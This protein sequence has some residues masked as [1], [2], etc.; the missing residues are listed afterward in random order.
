MIDALVL[1]QAPPAGGLRSWLPWGWSSRTGA[2]Q[3]AAGEAQSSPATCP[4]EEG[5]AAPGLG[6][7]NPLNNERNYPQVSTDGLEDS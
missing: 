2:S 3:P 7:L 1:L 6:P 5:G 4:V